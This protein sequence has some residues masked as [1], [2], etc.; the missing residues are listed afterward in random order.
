MYAGYLKRA[1]D[2]TVA[3]GSLILFSPL[4]AVV[5]ILIKLEDGGPVLFRQKRIGLDSRGFEFLKFR[6][7]PVN[8]ANVPSADA[9]SIKITRIGKFIRRTN[10]DELPQLFNVLHGEMSIVGPRPAIQSQTALLSLR[11]EQGAE[12]CTPGLT[13]LAQVNAYDGMSETEKAAF[14]GEYASSVSFIKDL[15]IIAKTFSY[16]TRKPPVY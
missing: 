6:S 11:K 3:A 13:G 16:L 4:M 1:F 2:I 15:R 9:E 12:N 5:A 7:M 10:I 8:A 14:D